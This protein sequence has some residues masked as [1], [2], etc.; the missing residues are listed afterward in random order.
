MKAKRRVDLPH[1]A[2]KL[3]DPARYKVLYGGRAAGRSWTVARLLLLQAAQRPLRI[4]CTREWQR[5]VRESVHRLLRDQIDLLG[6]PGY[7][8]TDTEIRHANGSLFIFAGL[9][10]NITSI[11]STE[12][13]DICW[14]EEAERTSERSWEVLL[15]TIR[16]DGSEV[17]ATFNPYLESDPTYQR[18]VVHPP[19][20][21]VSVFS[22]YRDNPWVSKEILAEIEHLRRVD[23]DGYAHV[24]EGHCVQNSEA[25]VL[26]GK[27]SI[28]AFEPGDDWEGPFFGADWGFSEDPTVLVKCWIYQGSLYIEHAVYGY[29]VDLDRTPELFDQVPDSRRHMIRADCSRPETISHIKQRRFNITG[30]PKWSGSVQDGIAHLRSYDRIVV[31]PRNREYEQECRLWRWKVD[32]LSGKPMNVLQAGNDHGPDA[33]RYALAPKIQRHGVNFEALTS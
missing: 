18:F 23:P 20:D 17:W 11:K 25:Q 8:H 33:T 2:A 26:H 32:E 28:E 15:P 19:P 14:V 29:R 12:G 3:I 16:K 9:R 4:L 6:V 1:Y 21:T 10:A 30:A 13:I 7:S 22:T 5:S 27:W 31:H 24:Y